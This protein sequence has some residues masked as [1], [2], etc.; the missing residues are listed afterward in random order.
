MKIIKRHWKIIQF[1][2]DCN[3]QFTNRPMLGLRK[4]PNL[5]NILCR[6]LIRYPDTDII[7]TQK[8]FPKFCH[9]LALCKYCPKLTKGTSLSPRQVGNSNQNSKQN[10]RQSHVSPKMSFTVL[11]AE[12]A[13]HNISVKHVDH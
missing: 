3:T 4:Q 12:N 7:Q 5:N 10:H 11:H 2:D 8:Y 6:A 1:S 13:R 9:R